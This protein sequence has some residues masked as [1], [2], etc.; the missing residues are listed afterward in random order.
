MIIT[1]NATYLQITD[2]QN[3]NQ[4]NSTIYLNSD[5]IIFNEVYLILTQSQQEDN[6]LL[7]LSTF[8]DFLK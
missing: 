6:N 2:I 8:N 5:S 3:C 7:F 4:K 1:F